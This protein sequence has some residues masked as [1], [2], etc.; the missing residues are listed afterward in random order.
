MAETNARPSTPG[1]VASAVAALAASGVLWLI[2]DNSGADAAALNLVRERALRNERAIELLRDRI[3]VGS[4][5]TFEQQ[6]E[7]SRRIDRELEIHDR[8]IE[9]L[10][11]RQLARER[12]ALANNENRSGNNHSP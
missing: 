6:K 5:W 8:R 12:G 10:E 1:L 4:R 3:G 7:Y 2:Q 9:R 11:A